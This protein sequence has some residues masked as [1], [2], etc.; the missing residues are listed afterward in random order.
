M[1]ARRQYRDLKKRLQLYA[2]VMRLRRSGFGYKQISRIIK[3]KHGILLNPGMICNWIRGRYILS[4][5][6]V[7]S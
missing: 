6:D 4:E 2:E 1:I 3:E 5:D 7:I